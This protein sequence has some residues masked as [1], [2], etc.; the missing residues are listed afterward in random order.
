MA[1]TD[2]LV[3]LVIDDE[4]DVRESLSHLLEQ[5]GWRVVQRSNASDLDKQLNEVSPNLVIS[6]VRM[7]GVNGLDAFLKICDQPHCPP[8]IFVS[9]HGDIEMAVKAMSRGAYNFLEKPY[10]PKRLLLAAKHAGDQD[11]LKRHNEQL[12][13]QV[14]R[15]SGLEN[16]LLGQSTPVLSVRN[17]IQEYAPSEAPVMITGQTGTGKE[18]AARAIHTLSNRYSN[19]FITVNCAVIDENHFGSMIFGTETQPGYVSLAQGGTLFLDE[20]TELSPHSQAQLLQL[21]EHKEYQHV[22]S[23]DVQQ[24]D[25]RILSAT[26]IETDQ[27]ISQGLLRTDLIY[28]LNGLSLSM[29]SLD[30]RGED[31]GL[32][33]SHYTEQFSRAYAIEVPELSTGDLTWLMTH[34]WPGNVRELMHLAERRVLLSRTRPCSVTDAQQNAEG[35]P[36]V[37]NKLRPAVAAFERALISKVLVE[38]QGRMDDVAEELGIGRRTLNEKMVKLSMDKQVLLNNCGNPPTGN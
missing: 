32:L 31:I 19:P 18:L 7:P 26:N 35:T 3:A 37:S 17:Q 16:L 4:Q 8:V 15:L 9:A 23:I 30:E 20:V 27:I 11:R 5:S 38:Q 2:A 13:E 21:I 6:D 24:A 1:N 36:P 10:D 25:I 28:R 14:E 12:Q 34:S 29:P 22:G 33:F